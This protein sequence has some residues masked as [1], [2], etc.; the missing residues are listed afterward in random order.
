MPEPLIP[1]VLRSQ[2]KLKRLLKR[3]VD[4]QAELGFY[5][6]W[7]EGLGTLLQAGYEPSEITMSLALNSGTAAVLVLKDT[8]KL[9]PELCI[10]SLAKCPHPEVREIAVQELADE[11]KQLW[12]TAVTQ[13]PIETLLQLNI[14]PDTLLGFKAAQ[15]HCLLEAHGVN[16]NHIRSREGWL[17]Y[18]AVEANTELANQMWDHGFR[19]VDDKDD[20]GMNA[21]MKLK[22]LPEFGKGPP[23]LRLLKM[24]SWLIEKGADIRLCPKIGDYSALHFLAAS[25]ADSLSL[26]AVWVDEQTVTTENSVRKNNFLS[27][28][29]S[30]LEAVLHSILLYDSRDLC[31]CYCSPTGC[32]PLAVFLGALTNNYLNIYDVNLI[33]KAIL[34]SVFASLQSKSPEAFEE[35]I[36]PQALRSI[37]F[38]ALDISHTCA[39]PTLQPTSWR[40][41]DGSGF[42]AH[43][44]YPTSKGLT[45]F[46]TF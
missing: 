19:D 45:G 41:P 2:N 12:D 28:L 26:W 3:G 30:S 21:L 36:I 29:P 8:G 22:S 43:P 35:R 27:Q 37:T 13:L 46:P 38:R 4:F 20:M 6:S 32:T 5:T 18:N 44:E 24:A 10:P 33:A 1:L 16:T 9:Y 17:V 25:L 7:P 23:S 39:H 40:S 34:P 15:V 42:I 11:R 31:N 14:R